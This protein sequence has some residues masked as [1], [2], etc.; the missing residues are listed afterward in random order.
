MSKLK[1]VIL[2][3]EITSVYP[4]CWIPAPE[5]SG[6]KNRLGK[7]R[8]KHIKRVARELIVRF[9]TKFSEEFEGNKKMLSLILKGATPKVRNQIAGYICHLLAQSPSSE[10]SEIENE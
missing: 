10:N 9:P 4:K 3:Y 7:V 6:G 1:L 2:C 8:I 5:I